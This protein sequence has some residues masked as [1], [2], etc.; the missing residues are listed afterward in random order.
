VYGA[1]AP[2]GFQAEDFRLWIFRIG[3]NQGAM[4][5]YFISGPTPQGRPRSVPNAGHILA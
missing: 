3:R 5:A 4:S 2:G 1:C